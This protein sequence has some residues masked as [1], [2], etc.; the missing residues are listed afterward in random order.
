MKKIAKYGAFFGFVALFLVSRNPACVS[1]SVAAAAQIAVEPTA[2]IT[3]STSIVTNVRI[4]KP[5]TLT[6]DTN[7]AT[8]NFTPITYHVRYGD[9]LT[10]IA[11]RHSSKTY[12]MSVGE[13]VKLNSIKNPNHILVGQK[14][15]LQAYYAEEVRVLVPVIVQAAVAPE[16]AVSTKAKKDLKDVKTIAWM[17][18]TVMTIMFIT[19]ARLSTGRKPKE[20]GVTQENT[21]AQKPLSLN[22]IKAALLKKSGQEIDELLEWGA[23]VVP[24]GPGSEAGNIKKLKNLQELLRQ[25]PDLRGV[26]LENWNNYLWGKI[27]QITPAPAEP[28]P[29]VEQ[30][31]AH[32]TP[33]HQELG[34]E[35]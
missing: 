27:N 29:S 1:Q 19:I 30:K 13:I 10:D 16:K 33:P 4:N 32:D 14:L 31:V 24:R 17:L 15:N 18:L 34:G 25:N 6:T 12:K 9:N 22:E 35:G 5:E 2:V 23:I 21:D 8:S 3:D 28:A 11:R 26:P 20:T 7:P